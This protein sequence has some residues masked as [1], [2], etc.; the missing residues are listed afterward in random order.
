MGSG[1]TCL[2][3]GYYARGPLCPALTLV[4][5]LLFSL[6]AIALAAAVVG[7]SS[8]LLGLLIAGTS[9]TGAAGVLALGD[10][11][12]ISTEGLKP[13]SGECKSRFF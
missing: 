10:A 7:G 11:A 2:A 1:G 8:S 13:K 4:G 6:A 9:L 3:W 5:A 12:Q